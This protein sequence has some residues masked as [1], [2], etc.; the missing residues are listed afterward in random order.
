MGRE[1]EPKCFV[2]IGNMMDTHS[3][4]IPRKGSEKSDEVQVSKGFALQCS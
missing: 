4:D 3:S 2:L 1:M